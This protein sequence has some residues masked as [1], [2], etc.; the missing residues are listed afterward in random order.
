MIKKISDFF[1]NSVFDFYVIK[2][3][4]YLIT[5]I[6]L[7]SSTALF[8]VYSASMNRLEE[9][10]YKLNLS[11]LGEIVKLTDTKINQLNQIASQIR[12]DNDARILN[13]VNSMESDERIRVI[14]SFSQKLR[15]IKDPNSDIGSIFVYY[16]RA[17]LLIHDSFITSDPEPYIRDIDETRIKYSGLNIQMGAMERDFEN[18]YDE[19]KYIRLLRMLTGGIENGY[20]S[21]NLDSDAILRLI[22][23]VHLLENESLYVLDGANHTVM[24]YNDAFNADNAQ[25]ANLAETASDRFIEVNREKFVICKLKSDYSKFTFIL[26]I[27]VENIYSNYRTLGE[28][29]ITVFVI[30]SVLALLLCLHVALNISKPI[31]SLYNVM[32]NRYSVQEKRDK[33]KSLAALYHS[34]ALDYDYMKNTVEKNMPKLREKLLMNL[35]LG[36]FSDADGYKLQMDYTGLSLHGPEFRV[37]VIKAKFGQ[38]QINE[39]SLLKMEVLKEMLKPSLDQLFDNHIVQV[40]PFCLAVILDLNKDEADI[41]RI[42]SVF[43]QFTQRTNELGIKLAIGISL[44]TNDT[45]KLYNA[46]TEALVCIQQN[47]VSGESEVI[48]YE[49]TQSHGSSYAYPF[50][51]EYELVMSLKSIDTRRINSVIEKIKEYIYRFPEIKSFTAINIIQYMCSSIKQVLYEHATSDVIAEFEEK[52][53]EIL[54]GISNDVVGH[55][56]FLEDISIRIADYLACRKNFYSK[57][58]ADKILDYMNTHYNDTL[59]TAEFCY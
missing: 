18:P 47:S 56:G 43:S 5:A 29:V 54:K 28:Y 58:I 46:F 52:N 50:N 22:K 32:K 30:M 15:N 40:E 51:L 11:K 14:L 38:A 23:T 2:N 4:I 8:L 12:E 20:I 9:S 41:N 55:I 37:V 39:K 10:S 48:C 25:L 7:I 42:Y 31:N 45:Q 21:V 13:T 17:G 19:R 57:V 26:L 1:K 24:S 59:D 49:N 3:V 44:E 36:N 53:Q 16:K 34:M 35:L 27:P 6:I 33:L